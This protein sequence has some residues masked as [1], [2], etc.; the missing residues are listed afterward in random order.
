MGI[1]DTQNQELITSSD[2]LKISGLSTPNQCLGVF[3]ILEMSLDVDFKQNTIIAFDKIRYLGN[4]GTVIRTADWF[5]IVH[6]LCSEDSVDV[7]NPKSGTGD[8][9]FYGSCSGCL[10]K[11]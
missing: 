4:L 11:S 3:K 8:D 5:G 9:G 6:I 10:F 1:L 7:F 2:L